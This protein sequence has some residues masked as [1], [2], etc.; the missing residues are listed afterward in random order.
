MLRS[1]R[2]EGVMAQEVAKLKVASEAH[3]AMLPRMSRIEL[4]IGIDPAA[5]GGLAAQIE[6]LHQELQETRH[7]RNAQTAEVLRAVHVL[8]EKLTDVGA[9]LERRLQAVELTAVRK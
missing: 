1:Y 4:V 3:A 6:E 5:G 9:A 8:G 7:E 2:Q